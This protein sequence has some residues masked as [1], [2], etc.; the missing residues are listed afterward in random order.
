MEQFK[1]KDLSPNKFEDSMLKKKQEDGKSLPTTIITL[2]E[3]Y[4]DYFITMTNNL[5]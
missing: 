4:V 2:L 5:S 1:T 3:V